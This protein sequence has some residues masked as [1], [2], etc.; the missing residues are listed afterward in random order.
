[1]DSHAL[2]HADK[3]RCS[4]VLIDQAIMFGVGIL[5]WEFASLK[6]LDKK[7]RQLH[8]SILCKAWMFAADSGDGE[9]DFHREMATKVKKARLDSGWILPSVR[10]IAA[11]WRWIKWQYRQW[12]SHEQLKDIRDL[13]NNAL[14][15]QQ[16]STL[17]GAIIHY[18]R[19]V[20]DI[21][22]FNPTQFLL[23]WENRL[24]SHMLR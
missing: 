9:S 8:Q 1:M 10:I 18:W 7:W 2:S 24:Q 16:M 4:M 15:R 14:A 19:C 21:E 12:A 5:Q 3:L 6:A 13:V 22:E 20:D 17:E 11:A 23:W